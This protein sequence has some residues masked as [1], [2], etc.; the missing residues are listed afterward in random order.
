MLVA[1]PQHNS[2]PH[3][4]AIAPRLRLLFKRIFDMNCR[5]LIAALSLFLPG[6]FSFGF[7]Q[8]A[9]P[10]E[11]AYRKSKVLIVYD[12]SNSMWGEL[13]DGS[14]KYEA[15]R[16]ALTTVAAT[17]L[18]GR[19]IG[20]RAYGH[21]REG[22]CRDSELVASFASG[23][24][25][26]SAILKA[27]NDI[28]PTGKT[29]ITYS[30]KE[31][32]KDL[33]GGPGDI[34]LISDGIETCDI[35]PCELMR[36]WQAREVNIRVHV[37]GVGLNKL[38]RAAMSCIAEES[39]GEYFDANSAS[40]FEDALSE[41]SGVIEATN[42]EPA[43]HA[44]GYAIVY[45]AVDAAG[46]EY[47]DAEGRILKDG[48][49]IS[50]RTQAVGRGRNPVEGPG[51]YVLE[52][53]VLL[54]DGTIYEPVRLPVVVSDPGDTEVDVTVPA[55]ARVVA[56]FEE[57]DIAHKGALIRAYQDGREVFSFRPSDEALARPGIYE[58]R[59]SVDSDNQLHAIAELVA[60]ER[61]TVRFELI[62]TVRA[63]VEFELP[64]GTT[65]ARGAELWKDG[66]KKYSLHG[67]NGAVVQPG[68]Y[69]LRSG[70]QNLPYAPAPLTIEPVEGKTYTAALA[71]GW[72]RIQFG[73]K[74]YDYAQ[75]KLPARAKLHSSDRGNW[76]YARPDEAIPV[77]P[78]TYFVEG[79]DNDGFFDR[80][81]V[82]IANGET[83]TLTLSPIPL[84][85]IVVSYAPSANYALT[86]DR[87]SL[88][89]LDGQR[90]IGGILQ[91][92]TARKVLPGRYR[93]TGWKKA[94]DFV[95]QEVTVNVGERAT[96]ELMPIG[97]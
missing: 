56:E 19:K 80:P 29:P 71:A 61:T 37:V 51:E 32:L 48:V 74:P 46:R 38:E 26:T 79:F 76:S 84:G 28:R 92:G 58:F 6:I 82:S 17:S 60:G 3:K 4:Q 22:D 85:E 24:V 64:D 65:I 87:A 96:V 10:S 5:T 90:I 14:R 53:G 69:E 55:P 78:G 57:N 12:S 1:Q 97:E 68:T 88:T 40:G 43:E 47:I 70:D 7:A 49:A 77:A 30:L 27:A 86:P 54:R 81:S 39:G 91:P 73:G 21:R 9:G 93:V 75:G 66:E 16:K 35:D 45:R 72:L 59:S 83:K 8:D 36:E 95:D 11:Q 34:L 41:A 18:A 89:A 23:E 15:G 50:S 52:A 62:E 67:S 2:L 31:G 42:G 13:S 25:A 44:D 33:G 63:Y 94:G 20:F